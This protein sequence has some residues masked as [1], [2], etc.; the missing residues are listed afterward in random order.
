MNLIK[1]FLRN[2]AKS[3]FLIVYK[4]LNTFS[5]CKIKKFLKDKGV[6]R[7]KFWALLRSINLNDEFR[8]WAQGYYKNEKIF[9]KIGNDLTIKNEVFIFKN[10][11]NPHKTFI[12]PIIYYKSDEINYIFYKFIPKRKKLFELK[13][14]KDIKKCVEDFEDYLIWAKHEK[15]LHGDISF[16]NTCYSNGELRILDFGQSL[17]KTNP[18]IENDKI[19]RNGYHFKNIDSSHY[20]IDDAHSFSRLLSSKR[21][22]CITNCSYIQ[23]IEK[24]IGYA[25]ESFKV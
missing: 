7:I 23:E 18:S 1:N 4:F 11:V 3:V 25:Q 14:E 6:K 21:M 20:I 2:L 19:Y 16:G 24:L 9:I 15:F 22:A 12:M 8:T 10:L 17:I 5:K 13:N